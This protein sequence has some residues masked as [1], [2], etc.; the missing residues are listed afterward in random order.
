M[1]PEFVDDLNLENKAHRCT[2]EEV[3][4]RFCSG[5]RMKLCDK[6]EHL[7]QKGRECGFL[8]ALIG[9]SFA[10]AKPLPQDLDITWFGPHGLD[11]TNAPCGCAAMMDQQ[12]SRELF[13]ADFMYIPLNVD[14]V[15]WPEQLE[16]WGRDLG[17]DAKNKTERGT[18]LLELI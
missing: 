12:Y 5:E 3:R 9:G 6:L 18:L 2:I 17:F 15:S 4:A 13:G 8:Y 14:R 16:R 1:I 10:T 11:K 7:L